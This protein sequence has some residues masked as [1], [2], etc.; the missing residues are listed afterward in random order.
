MAHLPL[1]R[2]WR[3]RCLRG[4]RSLLQLCQNTRHTYHPPFAAPPWSSFGQPVDVWEQSFINWSTYLCSC[5]YHF[6]FFFFLRAASPHIDVIEGV[7]DSRPSSYGPI[8][9][10]NVGFSPLINMLSL[11]PQKKKNTIELAVILQ[12]IQY[13][14]LANKIVLY[15]IPIVAL[16]IKTPRTFR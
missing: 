13:G 2:I 12:G 10:R 9:Y 4:L 8:E 14:G 16:H 15:K 7:G 3:R 6:R 11:P 1:H 5:C